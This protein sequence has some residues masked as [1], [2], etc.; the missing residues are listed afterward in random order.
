M[1]QHTKMEKVDG[2]WSRKSLI[3]KL[4]NPSKLFL[5]LFQGLK[6]PLYGAE[7]SPNPNSDVFPNWNFWIETFKGLV[8]V[9]LEVVWDLIT[10]TSYNYTIS[11]HIILTTIDPSFCGILH[12]ERSCLL[13]LLPLKW[14]GNCTKVH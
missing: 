8:Y 11:C 1:Y 12:R 6:W 4:P 9:T 5:M 2:T 10:L 13:K 14:I 3:R 7:V